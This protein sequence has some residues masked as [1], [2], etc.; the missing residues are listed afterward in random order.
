MKNLPLSPDIADLIFRMLFS[1]IFLG[2]GAEHIFSDTLIMHLM[3]VW[4]PLPH[5]VSIGAGLILLT[6][7]F[8][9]L[10]GFHV[11]V[12]ALILSIFLVIVTVMVHV[13]GVLFI[14]PE[15]SNEYSWTWVILQRSNLVKNLCL[16]GVCF[17]LFYH[18]PT[19]Y[20]LDNFIRRKKSNF[21]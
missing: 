2:L 16:L 4:M 18:E 8:M 1:S 14:P 5:V 17:N 13:P 11:R 10:L 7:G 20:T 9:I 3:P 12:G 19:R 6:G 21:K 15:F